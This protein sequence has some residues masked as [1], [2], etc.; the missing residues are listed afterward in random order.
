MEKLFSWVERWTG[1]IILAPLLL[2]VI[3]TIVVSGWL[4][5]QGG[6][7][8]LA[9]EYGGQVGDF[10]GGIVNPVI[11]FLALVWLAR[12]VQMQKQELAET[13]AALKEAATAQTMLVVN[14]AA[15][16][17]ISALTALVESLNSEYTE[18]TKL[19]DDEIDL[20]RRNP[21][22]VNKTYLAELLAKRLAL[23]QKRDGYID[24]VVDHLAPKLRTDVD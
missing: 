6:E 9:Y 15:N 2:V 16:L 21:T 17:Q 8:K 3:W 7:W 4:I 12:G 22:L 11:A 1:R 18:L 5:A 10:F 19:I 20:G 23:K 13:R 14:S 24:R